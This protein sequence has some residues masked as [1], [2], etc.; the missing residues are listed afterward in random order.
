MKIAIVTL[1]ALCAAVVG[2]LIG[3]HLAQTDRKVSPATSNIPWQC[4]SM[5]NFEEFGREHPDLMYW[6]NNNVPQ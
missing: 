1:A 4:Q 3:A 2:S 6:C 5:E